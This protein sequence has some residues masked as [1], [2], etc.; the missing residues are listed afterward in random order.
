MQPRTKLAAIALATITACAPTTQLSAQRVALSPSLD[1]QARALA[2]YDLFDP[3][4]TRFRNLRAYQLSNGDIA[5]C[6]QQ[7]G[8]N[9]LGGYV[10]FQALYIRFTPGQTP[11]RK[12][13]HR[14]FLAQT[15]CNALD[16]GQ[17]LPIAE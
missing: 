3:E 2:S 15:A 17:G 13:L 9:R 6:G 10:G 1:Q 8:R 14:E 4:S 16:S 5:I 11:I 7:N 12:S